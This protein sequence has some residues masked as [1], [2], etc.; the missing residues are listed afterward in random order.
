MNLSGI[1]ARR[2]LAFA[3]AAYSTSS[4][5]TLLASAVH[6]AGSDAQLRHVR[7]LHNQG[8]P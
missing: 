8:E 5:T 7:R 3:L 1:V 4:P 6:A 2:A